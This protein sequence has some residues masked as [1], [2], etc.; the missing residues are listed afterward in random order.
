MLAD[1]AAVSVTWDCFKSSASAAICG[2]FCRKLGTSKSLNIFCQF[3]VCSQKASIR[4]LF[5]LNADIVSLPILQLC[6]GLRCH[7]LIQLRRA[8]PPQSELN[9]TAR[10]SGQHPLCFP[11]VRAASESSSF[12]TGC[13][14]PNNA[15]NKPSPLSPA[16]LSPSL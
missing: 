12:C 14:P 4:Q 7:F 9:G 6:F 11:F 8:H 15:E 3:A 10:L 13:I 1:F 2:S 16:G 5:H